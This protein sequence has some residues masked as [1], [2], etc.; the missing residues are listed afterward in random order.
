MLS[1]ERVADYLLERGLLSGAAVLD[2]ELT[3]HDASSRNRNYRVRRSDGSGY[4]LK[5][6]VGPDT[7]ATIANEAMVYH[8]LSL[9]DTD[10]ISLLPRLGGYDA[11]EGLL[12]LE[13]VPGAEDLH[14]HHLGGGRFSVA[15][16]AA[17]GRAL[18]VLHSRTRQ[19]VG[20]APEQAEPTAPWVLS[21]HQPDASVFRDISAAGLELIRIVQRTAGFGE[22]LDALRHTWTPAA[23]IH[24]DVK[25]GN[26]LVV[27]ADT[28]R[29]CVKLIDW[30]SAMIG[31]P[32]WDIG[33]A[34]SQY[35]S[36]W[37][38]SIPLTGGEVPERFP[39]L[40]AYPLDA[41][42]PALNACWIAYVDAV[43][44][45][46][47]AVE[48]ELTHAVEMAAARLLQVAFE[49]SQDQQQLMSSVVLHL[50]LAHNLLARPRE[51]PASLL[52]IQV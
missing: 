32:G 13:L 19:L 47:G 44:I 48:R 45:A 52:G 27:D 4:L 24:G 21:L 49:A 37:L 30:E 15:P 26:V 31:D 35:L 38:F 25:W 10:L 6:G 9:A 8:R 29:E 5:Q 46:A 2:E 12:V 39:E 23:L 36:F 33:S 3:V 14:A 28:P 34:L 1:H 7:Q 22:R 11:E 50:Q 18:G 16:A 42:K 51:A 41:M 40:A 43:G 17:L 20:E